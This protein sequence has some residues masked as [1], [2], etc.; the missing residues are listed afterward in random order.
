MGLAV[1]SQ[2]HPDGRAIFYE[3]TIYS[4]RKI[5]DFISV[6]NGL[7][8]SLEILKV[9]GGVADELSSRLLKQLVTSHKEGGRFPDIEEK[10][11][12]FQHSF[13]HAKAKKEGIIIPS[14]GQLS[15]SFTHTHTHWISDTVSVLLVRGERQLRQGAEGD[16]VDQG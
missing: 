14:E 2:D 5:S 11:H 4:K 10:L 16:A 7:Q 3:E 15:L 6:L 13:D 1:R 12:V 8:S 9:F